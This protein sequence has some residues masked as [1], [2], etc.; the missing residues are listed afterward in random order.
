M[1]KYF[2]IGEISELYHIGVDSLRYYEKIGL[3][4]PYRAESGYRY[5]SVHDIWRLNVIRELRELGF[6]MERIREYLQHHTVHST[7]ELLEEEKKTIEAKRLALQQMEKN[8]EKRLKTIEQARKLPLDQIILQEYPPRNC[9]TIPEGY[10]EEHE[11]DVLIK[12]LLNID[13]KHFYIIGNNQIGTVIPTSGIELLYQSVFL[14]DENGTKTIPGGKYLTVSY[15]GT[16]GKSGKWIPKL[17]QY[18]EEQNLK[19]SDRVLE[20]LWIDIHTSSRQ[21]EH[22]TQL[23]LMVE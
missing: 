10:A 4:Q 9:Y 7:L 6:G 8:V 20:L 22:I 13:K 16:Y 3:I 21:E 19:P 11:M 15:E 1:E 23:Q 14:I 18:A 2:K 5:Y 17:L 12:Q